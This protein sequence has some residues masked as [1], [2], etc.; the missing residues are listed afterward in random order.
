MVSHSPNLTEV[1]PLPNGLNGLQM[2]VTHYLLG[3]SS[4]YPSPPH[5]SPHRGPRKKKD[6]E[7]D[8]LDPYFLRVNGIGGAPF[9]FQW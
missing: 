7:A 5:K 6:Y 2:V 9:D 3:W 8:L 1:V 4:K